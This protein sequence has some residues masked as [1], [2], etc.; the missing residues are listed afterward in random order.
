MG[1]IGHE[2][3]Q[4]CKQ[5]MPKTTAQHAR[6]CVGGILP[7][8]LHE[9]ELGGIPYGKTRHSFCRDDSLPLMVHL[10]IAVYPQRLF[11]R[12]LKSV[13]GASLGGVNRIDGTNRNPCTRRNG[14]Q[15]HR[16]RDFILSYRGRRTRLRR[17]NRGRGTL[18]FGIESERADIGDIIAA[19]TILPES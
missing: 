11:E 10:H 18:R 14:H 6:T 12:C 5:A 3:K 1:R 2:C 13:S 4:S 19:P 9:P 15:G 17:G 16:F 8:C 7:Q